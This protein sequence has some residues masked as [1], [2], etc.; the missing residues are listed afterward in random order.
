[1]TKRS[2]FVFGIGLGDRM[3][4]VC[5]LDRR[6]GEVGTRPSGERLTL[7]MRGGTTAT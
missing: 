3:S 7:P 2:R 5:E 1:M 6:T 4:H